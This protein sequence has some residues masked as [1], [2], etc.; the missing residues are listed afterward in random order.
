MAGEEPQAG[1]SRSGTPRPPQTMLGVLR[2]FGRLW[3][4]LAFYVTCAM[5]TWFV[6]TRS[7][8]LL[9]NVEREGSQ[10]FPQTSAAE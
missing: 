4:F 6:Y 10:H 3:G 8:G 5:V 9:R 7:G 2:R 1:G